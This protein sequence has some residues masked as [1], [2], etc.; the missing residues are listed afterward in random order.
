MQQN[1]ALPPQIGT[2]S[3][4]PSEVSAWPVEAQDKTSPDRVCPGEE[5][6]RNRRRSC[7]SRSYREIGVADEHR[8]TPVDKFGRQY[9]QPALIGPPAVFNR[10]VLA[11]DVAGLTQA[12]E[13]C[14]H[15]L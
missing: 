2:E 4:Y 1:E 3:S 13:E 6:D 12:L 7:P 10:N 11:L 8:H 14:S 5:N 9:R 15:P